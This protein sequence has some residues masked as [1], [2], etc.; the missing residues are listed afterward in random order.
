MEQPISDDYTAIKQQLVDSLKGLQ[1]SL[2]T[3]DLINNSSS[4]NQDIEFL[5]VKKGHI[6]LDIRKEKNHN[7]PHF[8]ILF[9]RIHEASYKIESLEK[10]AGDMDRKYEKPMLDWAKNNKEHLL[11]AWDSINKGGSPPISITIG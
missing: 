8:H 11:K 6:K 1:E 9:K 2:A 10:L 4:N 7:L 3:I 5:I